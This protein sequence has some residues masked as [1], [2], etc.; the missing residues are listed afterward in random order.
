[1]AAK[2][3]EERYEVLFGNQIAAGLHPID[4]NAGHFR[5]NGDRVS[6]DKRLFAVLNGNLIQAEDKVVLKRR[7]KMSVRFIEEKELE[8]RFGVT[9]E[10]WDDGGLETVGDLVDAIQRG[11]S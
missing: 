11:R 4:R 10:A 9:M 2:P 3:C 8:A 6:G 5:Q 1:M 7:M